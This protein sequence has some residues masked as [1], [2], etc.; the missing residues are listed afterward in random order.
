MSWAKILTSPQ[1]IEGAALIIPARHPLQMW[2]TGALVILGVMQTIYG[3]PRSSVLNEL[4][5]STFLL[6]IAMPILGA[7]LCLLS[8]AVSNR[9]P[10]DAM[11][12]SCGGAFFLAAVFLFYAATY[13]VY[14]PYWY[15]SFAFWLS[16]GIGMGFFHRWCQLVVQFITVKR[17][18]LVDPL[19]GL[20]P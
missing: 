13:F 18:G 8:S 17:K 2:L 7:V 19:R 20:E 12:L 14:L 9:K 16:A 15:A 4:L 1:P 3:P 5:M 6:H 10:F 11:I